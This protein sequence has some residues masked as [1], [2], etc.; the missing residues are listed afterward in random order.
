VRGGHSI[1]TRQLN[2]FTLI[3]I[4][5]GVAWVYSVIATLAPDVFPSTFRSDDGSVAVYFE[6]AAGIRPV[7]SF[8][9]L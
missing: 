9:R 4:G 1:L 7:F 6:A 2:M 5:T 3:A 8:G